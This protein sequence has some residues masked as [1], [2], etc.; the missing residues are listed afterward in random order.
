[1]QIP[2]SSIAASVSSINSR[3]AE[4]AGTAEPAVLTTATQLEKSSES[5]PDRD[6]QGQGDGMGPRGQRKKSPDD[7][8]TTPDSSPQSAIPAPNLP[9]EP[10]SQL[11][12]LG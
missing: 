10:P 11:D 12:L 5:S 6:A 8:T 4:R 2:S 9:D 7:E 1:M 3:T